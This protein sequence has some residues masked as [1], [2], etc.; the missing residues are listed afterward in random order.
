MDKQHTI[1]IV[2]WSEEIMQIHINS[3][4]TRICR[5]NTIDLK[6]V[7]ISDECYQQLKNDRPILTQ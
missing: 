7:V 3:T 2:S 1:P 5:P 4:M 6:D